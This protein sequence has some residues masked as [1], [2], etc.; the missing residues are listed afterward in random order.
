MRRFLV[1]LL[2]LSSSLALAEG[3]HVYHWKGY[4]GPMGFA[5]S[6]PNEDGLWLPSALVVI[7]IC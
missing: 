4:K 3:K 6:R 7:S 1:G 5:H 2:L